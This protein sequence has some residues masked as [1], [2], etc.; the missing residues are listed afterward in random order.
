ML[1][2]LDTIVNKLIGTAE[3]KIG[4]IKNTFNRAAAEATNR[5]QV[6]TAYDAAYQGAIDTLG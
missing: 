4:T 2:K 3:L 5:A 6:R 1:A